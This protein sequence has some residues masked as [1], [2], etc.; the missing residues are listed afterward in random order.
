MLNGR[1]L[2]R[3]LT[4]LTLIFAALFLA[5]FASAQQGDAMFGGNALLSSGS[6]ASASGLCPEKGGFYPSVSA[7]VVFHPRIGFNIETTWRGSQGS[8][9]GQPF[10]P[11][12]TDF[13][14]L[15]QPNLSKKVGLDVM[16]GVGWQSTRFYLPY[17]TNS[18]SCNNFDSTRHFLVDV[19]GGL[20]YYVWG[21]LFVRPEVHYY[22]IQNNTDAFS[23]GNVYRVGASIGYTI[24]GPDHK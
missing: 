20:R 12:L 17:C 4:L 21:N 22:F 10:R 13:N 8:Y 23:N 2:L 1:F 14:A 15:Y 18:F 11:I 24:G 3:K 5:Q 6:C 9:S 16:G 7:D 19:G